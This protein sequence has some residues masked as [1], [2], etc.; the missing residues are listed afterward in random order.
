MDLA[1]LKEVVERRDQLSKDIPGMIGRHA[2][3]DWKRPLIM[4]GIELVVQ[5]KPENAKRLSELGL[6]L[7]QAR[8]AEKAS[9]LQRFRTEDGEKIHELEFEL[10]SLAFDV[11]QTAAETGG[12]APR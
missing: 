9:H 10:Y 6:Q 5:D 7:L 8:S 11:F 2:F 1:Y 3:Y 4:E 12:A